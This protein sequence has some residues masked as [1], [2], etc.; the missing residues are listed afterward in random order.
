MH[1]FEQC[2]FNRRKSIERVIDRGIKFGRVNL[3][4]RKPR[5]IIE[6][7]VEELG[8]C[9]FARPRSDVERAVEALIERPASQPCDTAPEQSDTPA[10]LLLVFVE[11]CHDRRG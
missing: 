11:P 1:R 4:K 2:L 9:R 3:R 6:V 7:D 5:A 8:S 10:R